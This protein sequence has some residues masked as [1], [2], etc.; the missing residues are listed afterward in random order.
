MRVSH[1]LRRPG[2]RGLSVIAVLLLAVAGTGTWL[3]L[4]PGT[5]EAQAEP[6]TYTVSRTTVKDTVSAS[7][8]LAAAKQADLD[9]AVAGT[10]TKVFVKAGDH[11]K[12]GQA[13]ARIDAASLRASYDSA[14]AALSSAYTAYDDDA[15]AGAGSTQLASD[16]AQIQSAKA[17]LTQAGN[18]LADATLR[19]SISGTVAARNLDVGDTVAGSSSSSGS[20]GSTTPTSSSSSSSTSTSAFT[21]LQPGRFTVTAS[22]S[23]DDISSVKKGMQATLTTSSSSASASS[24]GVGGFPGFSA[25]GVPGGQS[26]KTS[27]GSGGQADSSGSGSSGTGSSSTTIFGTVSEVSMVADTSSSTTTFPVTIEVTGVHRKL[28]AG[29]S[30]TASITTKQVADVLVVPAMALSSTGGKTYVQKIVGGKT[31][32]TEVTVG[33]TYGTQTQITKGLESGDKIELASVTVRRACGSGGSG[34]SS[35]LPSFSN[36]GGTGG[37]S[38]PPSF[39]G[40]Q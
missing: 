10:V 19:A 27:G 34:G 12:K 1:R 14:E 13:L 18:N 9:F 17:L 31:V 21:V 24:G 38:G 26:N 2:R 36:S 25:F 39:G 20:G 37:F 7:G 15:D 3:I 35:G 30:V 23:A 32:K 6:I 22:V 29:T 4:R 16:S 28:Y 40:G 5:S 8:T 33:Q 11:V